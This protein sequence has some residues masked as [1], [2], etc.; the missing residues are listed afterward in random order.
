MLFGIGGAFAAEE[1]DLNAVN[2]TSTQSST[3]CLVRIQ[4]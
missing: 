2:L 1:V 4:N 3:T